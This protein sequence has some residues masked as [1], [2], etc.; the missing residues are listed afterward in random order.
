MFFYC[1]IVFFL[2]F[3]TVWV[4][5]SKFLLCFLLF[6]VGVFQHLFLLRMPFLT[7]KSGIFTQFCEENNHFH[8][9]GSGTGYWVLGTGLS[10]PRP[11]SDHPGSRKNNL[12]FFESKQFSGCTKDR[13]NE[14]SEDRRF[15]S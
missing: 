11:I 1:M 7:M 9:G 3:F 14:G 6:T 4:F 8:S 12:F 5:F 15:G 2:Y 10:P 13:L